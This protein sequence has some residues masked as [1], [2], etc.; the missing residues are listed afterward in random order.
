M[1]SHF[2][3]AHSTAIVLFSVSVGLVLLKSNKYSRK[4]LEGESSVQIPIEPNNPDNNSGYNSD[5]AAY[6]CFPPLP[7]EVV[8]L[9]R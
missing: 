4:Y 7:Q 1:S 2:L 6:D 3:I 5:S 9:L 8:N